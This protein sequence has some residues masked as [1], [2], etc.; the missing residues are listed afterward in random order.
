MHI[1]FDIII[2]IFLVKGI[3]A[4]LPKCKNTTIPNKICVIGQGNYNMT[5]PHE[6][7]TTLFLHE[8][9]SIDENENSISIQA[10]LISTWKDTELK[11]SNNSDR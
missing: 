11:L 6:L 5:N 1:A 8:I 10:T 2:L 4:E 3:W 7:N 9:V